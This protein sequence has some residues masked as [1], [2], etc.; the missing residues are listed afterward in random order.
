MATLAASLVAPVGRGCSSFA[1]TRHCSRARASSASV[2]GSSYK[3]SHVARAGGEE[4][5]RSCC[6]EVAR[7]LT[8]D[9]LSGANPGSIVPGSLVGRVQVRRGTATR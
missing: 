8:A 1:T 6:G 4:A 7:V 3:P 9:E 2:S 5:V